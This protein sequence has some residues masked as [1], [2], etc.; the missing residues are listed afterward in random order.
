MTTLQMNPDQWGTVTSVCFVHCIQTLFHVYKVT[1]IM[2][3]FFLKFTCS[4]SFELLVCCVH[5]CATMSRVCV[6]SEENG[7]THGQYFYCTKGRECS[8][9]LQTAPRTETSALYC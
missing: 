4:N 1:L 8:G 7:A 3:L 6:A 2:T 9:N 5:I